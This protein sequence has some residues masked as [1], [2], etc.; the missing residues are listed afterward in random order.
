MTFNHIKSTF[1]W[2]KVKRKNINGVR[3]YIDENDN[4]YHSVTK[5]V[6]GE[7]DFTDWYQKLADQYKCSLEAGE[8]IGNYVMINAGMYG[9]RLHKYC[10]EYL[11]QETIPEF[12]DI[13]SKAHFDNIKQ[14][15]MM[16]VDNIREI[17]RKMFS[18][19]MGLAGTADV[20]A[21]WDGKLSVIDF[22]TTKRAKREEWIEG[23]F[24]QSTAYALMYEENTGTPINQIVIVFTGEDGTQ[25][26]YVKDKA[27]YVDRLYEV[28]GQ[29]LANLK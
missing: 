23:Y 1:K 22:K 5:V 16:Y 18:K 21:D 9:T 3:H 25:D 13:I 14:R 12:K 28:I 17:E 24:L 8:A 15:L 6:N 26:T 29:Y 27:Q 19:K 2:P 11:L 20:I 4:I 10:E 7:K